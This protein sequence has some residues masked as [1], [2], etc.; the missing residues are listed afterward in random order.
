MGYIKKIGFKNFRIFRELNE[1]ELAPI[2]IITGPNNSGKSSFFKGIKLIVNNAKDNGLSSLR[3]SE[4][5]FSSWDTLTNNETDDSELTA[6][7]GSVSFQGKELD[8]FTH[9]INGKINKVTLKDNGKLVYST[10]FNGTINEITK[11]KTKINLEFFKVLQKEKIA[12]QEKISNIFKNA[13]FLGSEK[14]SP[15]EWIKESYETRMSAKNFYTDSIPKIEFKKDDNHIQK[16]ESS[17]LEIPN[18]M[19]LIEFDEFHSKHQDP[20]LSELN[21]RNIIA[22]L[23]PDWTLKNIS[24]TILEHYGYSNEEIQRLLDDVNFENKITFDPKLIQTIREFLKGLEK[25]SIDLNSSVN[26]YSEY[27]P[28]FTFKERIVLKKDASFSFDL[29]VLQNEQSDVSKFINKHINNLGFG[30]KFIVREIENFAYAFEL[31]DQDK[32]YSFS[33]LGTGYSQ[34]IELLLKIA[35][36]GSKSTECIGGY[37]DHIPQV[38]L[39]EEPEMSLHPSLQSKLADIFSDAINLFSIQLIIETHSE[40]L[41]R[42]LQ[43]LVAKKEIEKKATIIYYFNSRNTQKDSKKTVFKKIEINQNGTLTEQFGKGFF[44]EATSWELELMKLN[45]IQAN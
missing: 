7:I 35:S 44:D 13:T 40:Y 26:S 27:E 39:I 38:L 9:F 21:N 2:S 31:V 36:V 20:D 45:S 22:F 12:N 43:Y 28:K 34:I 15:I 33:D 25:A 3:Y 17:F 24:R 23:N 6:K 32:T 4:G 37:Y 41:I 5:T 1:F 10:A 14:V 29:K 16:E 8:Y 42:K 11:I 19:K 18:E 30:Q